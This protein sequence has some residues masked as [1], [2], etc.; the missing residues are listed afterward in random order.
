MSACCWPQWL[1]EFQTFVHL[2]T[3]W[4]EFDWLRPSAEHQTLEYLT[5]WLRFTWTDQGYHNVFIPVEMSPH[6]KENFCFIYSYHPFSFDCLIWTWK[7]SNQASK[8]Q[9]PLA[10]KR[11]SAQVVVLQEKMWNFDMKIRISV[12]TWGNITFFLY[13]GNFC[14]NHCVSSCAESRIKHKPVHRNHC[15]VTN[16]VGFLVHWWLADWNN[17]QVSEKLVR[18]KLFTPYLE[19]KKKEILSALLLL[20]NKFDIFCPSSPV[21]IRAVLY[22]HNGFVTLGDVMRAL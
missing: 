6:F 5:T 11:Y 17:D 20:Q 2:N 12:N 16:I 19:I 14:A 7:S 1:R 13:L 22:I 4:S 15:F 8:K 3:S 18:I 10:C 21:V 9:I